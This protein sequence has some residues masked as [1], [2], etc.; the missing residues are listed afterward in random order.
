LKIGVN[1]NSATASAIKFRDYSKPVFF[2]VI[3]TRFTASY[4]EGIPSQ[5][6]P[7]FA[8]P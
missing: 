7:F 6:T 4:P 5:E 8:H 3:S 2:F 1:P